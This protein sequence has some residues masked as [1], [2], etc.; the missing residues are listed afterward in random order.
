MATSRYSAILEGSDKTAH[1]AAKADGDI[2][3]GHISF[4][5]DYHESFPI[6]VRKAR[7]AA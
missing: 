1:L 2:I 5:S 6:I 4:G 3:H 7:V